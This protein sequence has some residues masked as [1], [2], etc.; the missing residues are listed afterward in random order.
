MTLGQAQRIFTRC[1]GL[2]IAHLYEQGYEA[3]WGDAY[4]D[5]R[6]HGMVGVKKAYGHR[7]SCHKSRLAIDLNLFK[8][9][10]WL[11]ASTDHQP[12]GEWWEKLGVKMGIPLAWGGRFN[13]GN[14]YSF[15]WQ[16]RK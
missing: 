8:D 1:T 2:L 5:P 14:H 16:G 6:L 12:L 10:V 4:R 13:D 11:Q 9:E 3:T 15:E 7:N